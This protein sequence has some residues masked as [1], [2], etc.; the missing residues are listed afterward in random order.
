VSHTYSNHHTP[1]DLQPI[2]CECSLD[3]RASHSFPLS[4]YL[5][6]FVFFSWYFAT[7]PGE[8]SRLSYLSL[9]FIIDNKFFSPN[10]S[11]VP[12]QLCSVLLNQISV[13][14]YILVGSKLLSLCIPLC[15]FFSFT[16]WLRSMF[17]AIY[18]RN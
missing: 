13:L 4:F 1:L 10:P 11:S 6:S 15:C 7:L 12:V 8:S 17:L 14:S 16:F 9:L 3:V 2:M 18:T 5:S